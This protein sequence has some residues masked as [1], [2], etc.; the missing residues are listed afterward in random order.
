L[1]NIGYRLK[2]ATS[3]N[4]QFLPL[5]GNAKRTLAQ[6]PRISPESPFFSTP[7]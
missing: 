7:Q 4:L 3:V 6:K 2:K 1:G 5:D